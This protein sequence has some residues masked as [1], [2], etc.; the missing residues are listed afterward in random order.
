[1]QLTCFPCLPLTLLALTPQFQNPPVLCSTR[2]TPFL[3]SEKQIQSTLGFPNLLH[4]LWLCLNFLKLHQ[5]WLRWSER[6]QTTFLPLLSSYWIQEF[7]H[8]GKIK[9]RQCSS[10]FCSRDKR[11]NQVSI[12]NTE[13]ALG[14]YDGKIFTQ[15][16]KISLMQPQEGVLNLLL[17]SRWILVSERF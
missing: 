8:V 2:D 10:E 9:L 11:P 17:V 12:S 14:L 4:Q 13:G 7:S 15:M 3:E 5:M 6:F 16:P 1:M